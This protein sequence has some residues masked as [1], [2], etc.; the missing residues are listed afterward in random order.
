MVRLC[1]L[2]QELGAHFP[3]ILGY[4]ADDG[5]KSIAAIEQA[6]RARD[7]VALV[8][9]AHSLKGEALQFGAIPLG[10]AAEEVEKAARQGIEERTFPLDMVKSVICLRPLFEAALEALRRE[11]MPVAAAVPVAMPARKSVGGFGR[12]VG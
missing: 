1:A 11:A 6:V 12:K 4:F 3:R 10:L 5:L 7:A 9:P 8:R 2:R